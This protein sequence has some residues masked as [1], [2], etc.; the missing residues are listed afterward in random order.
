MFS[1]RFQLSAHDRKRITVYGAYWLVVLLIVFP[2]DVKDFL[3]GQWVN[4]WIISWIFTVW[5]V[6]L[7]KFLKDNSFDDPLHIVDWVTD[8]GDD[9]DAMLLEW[10]SDF[11][12][13][14][15]KVHT[16]DNERYSYSQY[17]YRDTKSACTLYGSAGVLSSIWNIKLSDADL[18][19]LFRFAQ[20]NYWYKVGVGNRIVTWVKATQKRWNNKYPDK[21]VLYFLTQFWTEE[22]KQAMDK[23]YWAVGWYRGNAEYGKDRQDGVINGKV[24]EPSTYGHCVWAH[25]IGWKRVVLDSAKIIKKYEMWHDWSENKARYKNCYV[26]LPE[27]EAP[28]TTMTRLA[29]IRAR[30]ATK[31]A[32]ANQ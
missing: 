28:K 4:T 2:T 29:M 3:F 17:I 27:S 16:Q 23:W 30:R 24:F 8:F 25:F 5:V 18:L 32:T 13:K 19:D 12:S 14:L 1:K 9:E 11:I 22:L 21:K 15:S 20:K 6:T 26:Y 7:Q 31:K 10:E